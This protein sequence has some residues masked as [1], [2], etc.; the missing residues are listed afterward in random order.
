MDVYREVTGVLEQLFEQSTLGASDGQAG[1]APCGGA[2][3]P[4][5]PLAP[6]SPSTFQDL[7]IQSP[8][9]ANFQV[10]YTY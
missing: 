1:P 2:P 9:D 3:N 4:S 7:P 5:S 6:R 8:A 10:C